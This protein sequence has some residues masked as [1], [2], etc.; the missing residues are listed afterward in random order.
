MSIRLYGICHA[1][2]ALLLTGVP[3]GLGIAA[4][5]GQEHSTV[6]SHDLDIELIPDT[7]ELIGRDH[8][9][10]E[11]PID[12]ATV[13]FSIAPTLHVESVALIARMD[14]KYEPD[15]TLELTF[16]TDTVSVPSSQ[17]VVITLP[18]A[19]DGQVTL[20]WTYRGIID[21]PPK[22]PRHLRFVTPSETAGHIGP[23]GVYLSGE[24]QWYPDIE[25]S[26]STFRL[27][28]QV[29]DSWTVVTQGH[30]EAGTVS[31][32]RVSSMWVV[33]ERSEALTLVA[34][35]FVTKSRTWTSRGGQPIELATYFFADNAHL[36][37][38]YLDA[39][40]T[41]L[42]AYIPILGEFPFDRFSVVENFFASGL[43]MPSFTLLGSGSIQRHYIQPYALGHEIVHSWIG[44]SVFNRAGH[45]NWVEGLTT[46]LANYYWHELTHDDRQ[47]FEQRRMMLEGYSVYVDP[48]QDYP[49]ARFVTKSD[50]KD[51]A[52]GY[53]KSAFVFH[54]LRREIGD[55]AFW[56]GLKVFVGQY[57]NRPADW[58]NIE[59]VFAQESRH[60]LR[61]FFEQWIE[62]GGAPSLSLGA[63]DAHLVKGNDGR[64]V[65]EMT[66]RVRQDGP[67]FR[68]P[69][70]LKIVMKNGV[71]TK[72]V[73]V[74]ASVESTAHVSVSD[75]PLLVQLDP[76]LT[77]FRRIARSQLTPM[78][79][80]YATDR[81]RTV[82]G[83]F[84]DPASPLQRIITRIADQEAR[85]SDS[86]KTQ[87]LSGG[88]ATIPR[89][90]SVLVLAGAEQ[91][92]I[93]DPIAAES[94]GDFVRLGEEGFRVDGETY[95]GTEMAVLLTCRRA[96]APGS[97]VTI[98]YGFS[99]AAVEKVSRFLFYYGWQSYVVFRN[100]TVVK[101]GLWQDE[102][103]MKEVRI[104]ATQ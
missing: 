37:D 26:F 92:S 39:T 15:S 42:D 66:I 57:R 53:Q 96:H 10:A 78:L 29:P 64:P 20:A 46:F 13:A 88:G 48:E 22:E 9:N 45:G 19:H 31:G 6:L 32:G 101:R 99:S 12:A 72:W 43:G 89:N 38:E 90:G 85:L 36:A 86:R 44:N 68:M 70:P 4:S 27:K 62:R 11:V 8:V 52:I 54:Q 84:S 98:L 25:G 16:T 28:V 5:S 60:D 82:V 58:R 18:R 97:V 59:A 40:A 69:V 34:N 33:P 67:T 47:A 83:A 79:N 30:Q 17:R 95:E 74:E 94:C 51:N 35:T 100:G 87:V 3:A 24:S 2:V 63:A 77:I 49:V 91:K 103:E 56:R 102:P 1:I 75:Q 7:H 93:V 76:E 73:P 81:T 104:H 21:D 71:E 23:E 50:E 61:S 55:D 80:G 65:W 14:Q 41:Y